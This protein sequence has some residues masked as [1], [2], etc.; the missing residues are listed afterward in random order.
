MKCDTASFCDPFHVGATLPGAGLRYFSSELVPTEASGASGMAP[1][2]V[3]S[4]RKEKN[5]YTDEKP[6]HWFRFLTN[7]LRWIGAWKSQGP[8]DQLRGFDSSSSQQNRY[9]SIASTITSSI[10]STTSARDCWVNLYDT[11]SGHRIL[12]THELTPTDEELNARVLAS[13]YEVG[14]W[15]TVLISKGQPQHSSYVYFDSQSPGKVAD[16]TVSVTYSFQEANAALAP[17]PQAI[18]ELA[19]TGVIIPK[20]NE[21][22]IY[23]KMYP[24]ITDV[25]IS[26]CRR[27]VEDFGKEAQLSL[28][29]YRDPEIEDQYPTIYVRQKHYDRNIIKRIEAIRSGYEQDLVGKSGWILLT[30]D[31]RSP[32]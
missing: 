7:S 9:L 4:E 26:L 10:V 1:Y 32:R 12:W 21:V 16:A 31:F 19:L 11:S 14:E 17:V 3:I 8:V 27:V 13:W 30:T 22:E 25:L 28:E 24:D 18:T 15:A 6:S 23:L 20:P 5:Q 29:V 2:V